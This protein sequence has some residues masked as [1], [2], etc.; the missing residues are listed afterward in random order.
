M[1]CLQP[2]AS[3]PPAAGQ[4]SW[5]V[6]TGVAV[7]GLLVASALL[8]LQFVRL[9]W[10]PTAPF[11]VGTTWRLDEE[12]AARHVP[13][14]VT[15]G[16]GYDGQ[17]FLGLAHDPLL[18]QRLAA[19]FDKPR[20]RARRPLQPLVG[21]LLA[22]GQTPAIPLA[23]LA[24]GPLAVALGCAA[25]GRLLAASGRSR[26]WGLGFAVVPGVVVGVTFG[27]AEP[28]ALALATLGLSLVL[29]GRSMAAGMAFAGAGLT[30]ESYLLFAVAAAA[31]LALAVARSRR[32]R[33]AAQAAAVLLPGVLALG[34]WWA[35]VAWHLPA[36]AGDR[37]GVAALGPPLGGWD[38]ALGL[39]ARGQ[40]V[41]DAPVGPL[42]AGL[43]V[44]SGLLAVGAILLGT[45]RPTLLGW[46]GL[47]MGLYG[48]V[49][50]GLLLDRFLSSMRALAPT[51]LAAALAMAAAAITPPW[52]ARTPRPPST[53]RERSGSVDGNAKAR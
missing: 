4:P 34:L 40:Y 24:V 44:G 2:L 47:L 8:G 48:L 11:V 7:A 19:G 45:R 41:P 20:Y 6:V 21:W 25:C 42:G 29:D 3:A 46:T 32:A 1:G 36:G 51:V 43:L 31:W 30:K 5:R 27:T 26:W 15:P 9:G 49:L 16:H 39:V 28:L 53:T 38:H 17:W 10:E 22:G 14:T 23:L 52:Q 18:H 33:A 50:S 12:L 35:Y 13:V 37:R